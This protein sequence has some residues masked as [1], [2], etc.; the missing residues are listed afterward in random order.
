MDYAYNQEMH[1]K[2][3]L[4]LIFFFFRTTEK[5]FNTNIEKYEKEIKSQLY[6]HHHDLPLML[7]R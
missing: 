4:I 7:I 3:M 2:A 5:F 6:H 1:S